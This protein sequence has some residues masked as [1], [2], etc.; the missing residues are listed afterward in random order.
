VPAP[1]N[2]AHSSQ[3]TF[4]VQAKNGLTASPHERAALLVLVLG[5][6][7]AGLLFRNPFMGQWD[8]FDYL[9]KCIRHQVSDLAFGRPLF[10]GINIGMWEL[11]HRMG[12]PADKAFLVAQGVVWIFGICGLICFYFC[13]KPLGGVRLGLLGVAWLGSTPVYLAYMGMVMT[14]VPSLTCLMA[15]LALLL[16]WQQER[17]GARL[18]ASALLFAAAVLMREQL[19]ISAAVF[20]FLILVD[21]DLTWQRRISA[22]VR[23]T[24]VYAVVIL[25]V[26]FYLA[27]LDPGYWVRVKGWAAV[28]PFHND[29]LWSQLFSLLKFAF[30][31]SGVALAVV[32]MTCRR[33]PKALKVRAVVS[34]M[35]L[36]PMLT[37]LPNADLR[38]QP[39]YEIATVPAFILAALVGLRM[40]LAN[41]KPRVLRRVIASVLL[42]HLLFVAGG[43]I[44][45]LRFNRVSLERKARVEQLLVNAPGDAVFLGG[46]YT[47]MLEFYRQSGI[48]P[49][50]SVIRS[51]WEWSQADL[52]H[53]ISQELKA[54]HPVYLLSDARVW[55]YLRDELADVTA[56]RSEFRFVRVDPGLERIEWM[57][58]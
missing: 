54:N 22:V 11:A 20:P 32:L 48:R 27:R 29:E 45:L 57:K 24:L 47:P 53:R 18:V 36:L 56:L 52:P 21:R 3:S 26:L 12:V 6:G 38:I 49:G 33:W 42:G 23:H 1:D 9:T 14:E 7:I 13:V 8:S 28:M 10:L 58:R 50:W 40:T 37:L 41:P 15:A 4:L 5:S 34:G 16:H 55:D 46:A 44:V 17:R 19:I 2:P 43:L 30:V 35:A 31:N 39:R 25:G 51:G